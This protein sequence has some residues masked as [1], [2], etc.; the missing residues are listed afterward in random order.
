MG[1]TPDYPRLVTEVLGIRHAPAELA[2]RLIEQALVVEDRHEHWRRIGARI[3]RNAPAAPGV[4][5]LRDADDRTIYVGKAVNLRRRLTAQFA[6][7][8]WRALHPSMARV[9]QVECHTVGSEIEALLREAILIRELQPIANVQVGRPALRTRAIPRAL[10]RDVIVLVPSADAESVEIVAARADGDVMLQRAN[11]NG[12]G[13]AQIAAALCACFGIGMSRAPAAVDL[14]LAPL[15]FSWLAG[16]GS[17]ATRLDPHDAATADA[18]RVRLI[19]LLK[20]K[21]LFAERLIPV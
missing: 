17:G 6:D 8:R 18:L 15:V 2:R 21:A 20:D 16:R 10:V 1:A 4:Y 3:C 13:L 14:P 11:R 19:A 5:V 12:E 9:T 7:R